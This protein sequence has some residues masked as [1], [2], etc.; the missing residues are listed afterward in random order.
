MRLAT[1]RYISADGALSYVCMHW[2]QMGPMLKAGE[3]IYDRLLNLCVWSKTNAGM[4]AFYRS[5]HELVFLFKA[6][7]GPHINNISLGRFGRNRS[8][9]WEYPGQNSF[10]GTAKSKLSLHPTAKPVALVADAIKDASD[11]GGIVLD[12]FGGSGSTLIAAEKTGRRARLIEFEPR[13][14]DATLKRWEALTGRVAEKVLE[15]A[16]FRPWR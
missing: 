2:S 8:N 16:S 9:I 7:K 14:V 1:Q 11:R 13:F 15:F 5:R 6:G 12:P 3:T 10:N 4:G